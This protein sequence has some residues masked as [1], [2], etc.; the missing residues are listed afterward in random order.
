M[1]D[2]NNIGIYNFQLNSEENIYISSLDPLKLDRKLNE[3]P[4]LNY[5]HE[6]KEIISIMQ[7]AVENMKYL[8]TLNF[9]E[10]IAAIRDLGMFAGSLKKN[11]L[12]PV[13]V[14]PSLESVL[15]QL[16]EITN[17][18]P[19]DTLIHY[20]IWNPN[21]KRQRR[22]TNYPDEVKLIQS[23]RIAMPKLEKAV[24][25][26]ISLHN[27]PIIS[28]DFVTICK[29]CAN[30]LTGMVEAI[31]FIIKNV[32]RK[33]FAEKLRPY[34]DE[35]MIKGNKY[36]GPGAVEM[37]LFIFDHLLW[38]AECKD[39]SYLKFKENFLPYTLPSFRKIYA[40]FEN[41]PSLLMILSK[42]LDY[43]SYQ[44]NT[45]ILEGINAVNELFKILIKFRKPHMKVVEQAYIHTENNLREQ[46]SGGYKSDMLNYLA[47]M[48]SKSGAQLNKYINNE[49]QNLL[50]NR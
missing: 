33:V 4:E 13:K 43:I 50:S 32:S 41:S 44:E 40:E 35:I 18:V 28:P 11:N 1:I 47:D 15:I 3:L 34:F 46:G 20:S 36:L 16:G 30:N 8:G 19:R 49:Q 24:Y 25:N 29:E 37:P 2:I 6:T 22:Y 21:G 45:K 48:T 38:S 17:M 14:I 12:E 39:E 42:Q 10:S 31:V 9:Y 26:L 27:I 5:I 7:Y 23:A